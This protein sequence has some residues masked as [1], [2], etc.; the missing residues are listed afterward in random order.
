MGALSARMGFVMWTERKVGGL[1]VVA[2]TKL[3]SVTESES[4]FSGFVH[5]PDTP[6]HIHFAVTF[7]THT[8]TPD[9][10]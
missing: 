7:E 4:L 6:I 8:D 10:V 5:L 1:W 2:S 3:F 9:V